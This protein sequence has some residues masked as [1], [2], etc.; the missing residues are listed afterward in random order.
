M[1]ALLLQ[2]LCQTRKLALAVDTAWVLGTDCR[3]A[4]NSTAAARRAGGVC[5]VVCT[6]QV[7]WICRRCAQHT[8]VVHEGAA[9][10]LK[11]LLGSCCFG[12]P[13]A[14]PAGQAAAWE[15]VGQGSGS[16]HVVKQAKEQGIGKRRKGTKRA[17]AEMEWSP[18]GFS[19]PM[20]AVPNKCCSGFCLPRLARLP[21][22]DCFPLSLSE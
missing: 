17:A 12:H 8:F 1:H 10:Q 11:L 21:P 18:G 22:L 5:V 14:V 6:L 2:L 4:S 7:P 3:C 13:A 15:A 16:K 19:L 9:Q 20:D